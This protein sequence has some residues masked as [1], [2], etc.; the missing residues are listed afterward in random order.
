MKLILV[1]ALVFLTVAGARAQ[2]DYLEDSL[3]KSFAGAR[4]DAEKLYILNEL[5]TYYTGVDS[6]LSDDYAVQAMQIAELSRD[7]KLIALTYLRN[8]QRNLNMASLEG[9]IMLAMQVPPP[10]GCP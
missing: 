2:K 1:V 10:D 8:G 7:R 4:T 9:K 3:K 5:S 6:K